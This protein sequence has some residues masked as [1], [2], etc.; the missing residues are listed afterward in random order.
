MANILVAVTTVAA[1]QPG[2]A[3]QAGIQVAVTDS[4]GAVQNQTF[5][6]VETPPWS[7]TFQNLADGAGSITATA[8]D[9]T[10]AAM[11][12]GVTQPFKIGRAHV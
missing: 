2:A 12:P 7:G 10:G 5:T 9:T 6:G 4:A 3:A 8:V 11:A 1:P